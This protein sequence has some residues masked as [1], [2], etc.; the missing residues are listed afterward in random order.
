[1]IEN[2]S[3]VERREVFVDWGTTRLR[4]YLCEG[5]AVTARLSGSG[6]GALT[7]PPASALR[8]VLAPWLDTWPG[9]GVAVCGMAG[10]RNGILEVPYAVAPA[11]ATAWRDSA[12]T[13]SLWGSTVTIAAGLTG[14]NTTGS[15]DVMRGEET[16]IFGAMHRHPALASGRHLLILPGTHCKWTEVRNGAIDRFHTA[17][18]GEL[19]DLLLRH[20]MLGKSGAAE[21]GEDDGF[22]EGLTRAA[23]AQA[24]LLGSLFEVRSG[25]LVG[26]RSRRWSEAFLSGLLIGEETVRMSAAFGATGESVLIGSADLCT[27]YAKA[28]CRL[29]IS[30][31]TLDGDECAVAGL[32]L[33]AGRAM[34]EKVDVH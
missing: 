9:I 8:G 25:Q 28:L 23:D 15:P 24:G 30:T 13:L 22:A 7:E 21:G 26:G 16:Q 12:Q 10:S 32:S 29:E 18:T 33:L 1:M 20:S 11:T 27:L 34:K 5:A 14:R 4:A 19:H 17:L 31:R 3:S 6:I 2:H